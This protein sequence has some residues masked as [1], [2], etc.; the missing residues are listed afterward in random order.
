MN[1]SP[2]GSLG[3][4]NS[5]LRPSTKLDRVL[6][7]NGRRFYWRALSSKMDL[8]FPSLERPSWLTLLNCMLVATLVFASFS[9]SAKPNLAI[10]V[11][12]STAVGIASG[13]V[14]LLLT[15]PFA[16]YPASTCLTMRELVTNLVALNY[17]KLVSRY[18]ARSPSDIWNALQLI[19]AEQ[20]GVE[21]NAVVPSA[22]F[23]QD[24]GAD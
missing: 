24:L 20:L 21:Q 10:G 1:L 7:M 6:P 19:V 15:S 23:V 4:A 13:I 2:L 5:G 14:L 12:V 16:I 17:N 9:I 11:I 8:R 3:L 18:S 22:R